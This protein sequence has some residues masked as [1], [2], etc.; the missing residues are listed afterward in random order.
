MKR[1]GLLLIGMAVTTMASELDALKGLKA[2]TEPPAMR[3]AGDARSTPEIRAIYYDALDWKGAPTRVFA[4]LGVPDEVDTPMPGIVLVHGGGGTAFREWVEKWNARG[5][6]AIAIAVEGQ[7]DEQ[8]P[9]GS[10]RGFSW[11]RHESGGLSRLGIYADSGEPLEEQWMFHAAADTILANTLLR[12]L[13]EVDAER[14]GIMGISWGG[15]IA[16]TVIG[17]DDR[18]AFAIP[19]YGCGGLADTEN[20]WGRALGN[21]ATYRQ[22]WDPL[23]RLERATM[24]TLWLSWPGD[25]HF[26]LRAQAA[27]YRAASGP[28]M[29][30]LIPGM[31]HSHPAGWTPPDSYAFA[32]SVVTTGRPWC[33]QVSASTE[34]GLFRA[35]FESSKPFEQAV[36]ISTADSGFTGLRTWNETPAALSRDGKTWIAEAELPADATAWF[37]NVRSGDLTVSSQLETQTAR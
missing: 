33:R 13:P 25:K 7:T 10:K 1:I 14:V 8:I 22:V 23:L 17:L 36:L 12:S 6:A 18:F 32:E 29:V 20:Q 21:N 31:N 15:V 4:W 37:I 3:D 11:K 35:V 16:S 24:P 30:S 2:L 9:D 5:F 26:D 34:D 27:S 19:T 28:V